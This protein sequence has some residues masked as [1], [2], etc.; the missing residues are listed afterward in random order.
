MER[1]LLRDHPSE[2]CVV[3]LRLNGHSV[4]VEAVDSGELEV[5]GNDVPAVAGSGEL[6]VGSDAQVA[7]DKQAEGYGKRAVDSYAQ[8]AY[9]KPV[10]ARGLE[11]R[12][13][14][15][16]LRVA[17]DPRTFHSFVPAL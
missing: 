11:G 16:I 10:A 4:A 9:G 3:G 7:Y 2:S 5:V 14:H 6:E 12:S 8:A 13:V 15:S 1:D 17:L